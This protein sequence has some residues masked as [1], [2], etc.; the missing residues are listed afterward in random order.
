M[1]NASF[2][3]QANQGLLKIQN[4]GV[5]GQPQMNNVNNPKLHNSILMAIPR[6]LFPIT[7]DHPIT[8]DHPIS[9]HRFPRFA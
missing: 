3:D 9:S 4:C 2:F 5:I 7:R 1:P 6:L 8:C